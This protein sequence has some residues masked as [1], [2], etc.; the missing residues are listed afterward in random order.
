M[1]PNLY[2]ELGPE[3][4]VIFIGYSGDASKEADVLA[5]LEPLLLKELDKVRLVNDNITFG[6]IKLWKWDSDAWITK[7]GQDATIT[8]ILK[9]A[10]IAVFVF[11]E[12][13]G[14]VAWQEVKYAITRNPAI[15]VLP[16]FNANPP[17]QDRM[18]TET[19]AEQWLDLL[20]KSKSLT[21]GWTEPGNNAI[22]PLPKYKSL[23]HLGK[24]A[25]ERLTNEMVRLAKK[26]A[27][28]NERKKTEI[29]YQYL[30]ISSMGHLIHKLKAKDTTGKWAYYFVLV[31]PE[32]EKEFLR[33]I[34]GDGTINLEDYGRVVASS[35]GEKPTAEVKNYLKQTYGFDI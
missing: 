5:S 13:V 14:K 27:I 1:S 6:R 8:P 16:F 2:S 9:R 25:A 10:D 30:Q 32:K 15:P 17:S 21:E 24:L 20:R 26:Q 12:R 35:Y 29:I 7:G 18:M 33:A 23:P 4:L 34:E 3:Y 28:V 31:L 22:P 11:N 19:V